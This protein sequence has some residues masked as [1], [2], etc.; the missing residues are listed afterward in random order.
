MWNQLPVKYGKCNR[1]WR[2]F[3]R[4]C[5][6][7]MWE[8]QLQRMG[9]QC[10]R[11]DIAVMLDATDIKVHQDSS[12]NAPWQS[13]FSPPVSRKRSGLPRASHSK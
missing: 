9:A 2:T 6:S 3:R 10:A 7:G 4:W 5:E 12:G 1:V 8:W 11:H 13:A